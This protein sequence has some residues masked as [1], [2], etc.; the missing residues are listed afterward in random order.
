MP[1]KRKKHDPSQMALLE[2]RTKTA[3]CVPAIRTAVTEWANSGY[4]GTAQTS[5]TLLNHW[6]HTDRRLPDGHKFA[7]YP[8]QREAIETLI[9]VYGA[10]QKRRHKALLEASAAEPN[11]RL[12][13]YDN[14]PRYCLKMAAGTG[15]TKVI[16]LA[17]VWQYFNAVLEGGNA[18]AATSLL[19]APNVIVYQRLRTDFAGGKIFRT[20]PVIPPALKIFWEF[21]CYMRGDSERA[22]SQSALYVAN[23]QQL[24][25]REDKSNEDEPDIMTMMLGSKPAAQTHSVELFEQR[26]LK[27]GNPVFHY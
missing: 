25:E 19:I 16:S 15:K 24:Y 6:F 20:D 2:A 3:P 26:I 11:L 14:F 21:N 22:S 13:Q 12:L 7:Y 5:K 18:Y 23:I 17:I 9:Y 1:R 8:F 4:K 10:A 27:R